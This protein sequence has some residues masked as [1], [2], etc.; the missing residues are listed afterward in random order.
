MIDMSKRHQLIFH[1]GY[2]YQDLSSDRLDRSTRTRQSKDEFTS[3]KTWHHWCPYWKA[4]S[5][6]EQML[7]PHT[8]TPHNPPPPILIHTIHIHTP[9]TP[10]IQPP[11]PYT[12]PS[13]THPSYT[14]PSYTHIVREKEDCYFLYVLPWRE[15]GDVWTPPPPPP[16]MVHSPDFFFSRKLSK[17]FLLR[18]RLLCM[19]L[20]EQLGDDSW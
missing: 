18:V 20:V 7:C 16:R 3:N 12:H 6:W 19:A 5:P 8:H 2:A 1:F 10:L 11:P 14:H 4:A 9:H 15:A 13:Y 17:H